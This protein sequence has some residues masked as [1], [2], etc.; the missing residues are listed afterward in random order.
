MSKRID[1]TIC[2]T[3]SAYICYGW[4]GTF[5]DAKKTNFCWKC[6][7]EVTMSDAGRWK[8]KRIRRYKIIKE[9]VK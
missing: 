7:R 4:I 3:G 1:K 2:H 5:P 9:G 6:G 8:H